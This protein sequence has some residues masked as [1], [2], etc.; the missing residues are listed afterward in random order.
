MRLRRV[1]QR[2]WFIPPFWQDVAAG[3][4]AMVDATT[5]RTS[6]FRII[7]LKR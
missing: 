6:L 1:S 2:D 5:A 3:F 4:A 7:D